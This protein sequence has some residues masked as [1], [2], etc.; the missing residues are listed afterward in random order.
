MQHMLSREDNWNSWK[1]DSCPNYIR[2][3][4][5]DAKPKTS[6]TARYVTLFNCSGVTQDWNGHPKTKHEFF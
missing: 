5:D 4:S 1:N 6:V 2:K 3:S